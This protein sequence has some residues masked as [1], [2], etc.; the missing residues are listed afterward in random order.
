[1]RNR[2]PAVDILRDKEQYELMFVTTPTIMELWEGALNYEFSGKE[3]NRIT[4]LI[5]EMNI[6]NLDIVAAKM[7]AEIEHV[8][9]NTPLELEDAMIAA[10]TIVQGE[11]L[12]T[13]DE[14]FAR[15]PGLRVLKY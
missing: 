9:K 4:M 7:S 8:L 2:K 6:L 3:K 10:I 5:A 13:K 11:T 15:I 12:I 1:M 14:H